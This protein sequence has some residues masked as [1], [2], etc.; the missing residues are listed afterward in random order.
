MKSFIKS[1]FNNNYFPLLF[2]TMIVAAGLGFSTPSLAFLRQN[3]KGWRIVPKLAEMSQ[4]GGLFEKLAKLSTAGALPQ[5]W[6]QCQKKDCCFSSKY[7]LFSITKA[8]SALLLEDV[9]IFLAAKA[10]PRSGCVCVSRR[11]LWK[12]TVLFKSL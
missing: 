1:V 3:D 11:S 2:L 9:G 8:G 12:L 6:V 10:T 4:G 7:F 5:K